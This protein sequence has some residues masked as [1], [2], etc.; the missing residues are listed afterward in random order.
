MT[1]A[2]PTA[3]HF[4]TQNA[5]PTLFVHIWP[6]SKRKN[7]QGSMHFHVGMV[8]EGAPRGGTPKPVLCA[9]IP[10]FTSSQPNYLIALSAIDPK[11]IGPE[12]IG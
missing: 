3:N 4:L 11:Q 8:G 10:I 6:P 7:V 5:L 1:W 2:H 12:E 9:Q